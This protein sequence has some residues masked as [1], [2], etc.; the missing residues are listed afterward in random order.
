MDKW[1]REQKAWG[2]HGDLAPQMCSLNKSFTMRNG[3]IL[4]QHI[5]WR[6]IIQPTGKLH[7]SGDGASILYLFCSLAVRWGT[8]S[9]CQAWTERLPSLSKPEWE[10]FLMI[11]AVWW[12]PV[13]T[14]PLFIVTLPCPPQGEIED[15]SWLEESSLG[16][17]RLFPLTFSSSH[18]PLLPLIF[19]FPPFSSLLWAQA[20]PM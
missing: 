3:W 8:G 2:T 6:A 11:S 15:P 12:R 19:S 4:A 17:S 14:L 18:F 5:R 9:W 10:I 7:C 1:R 13:C 16:Y 20:P